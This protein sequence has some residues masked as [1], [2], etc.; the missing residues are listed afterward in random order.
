MFRLEQD[1]DKIFAVAEHTAQWAIGDGS[2]GSEE[3]I[4]TF[5]NKEECYMKCLTK[6]RNGKLANGVTVDAATG[7]SC[8]CEYGQTGRNG[9]TV[10]IN[11]FIRRS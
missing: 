5:K 9:N 6:R 8:Y 3:R 7:Q 4:G 2:G 1:D 11:T 10:W